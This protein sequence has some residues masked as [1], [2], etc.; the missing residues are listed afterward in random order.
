MTTGE[1]ARKRTEIEKYGMCSSHA[2]LLKN[3]MH[4]VYNA[5]KVGS[6]KLPSDKYEDKPGYPTCLLS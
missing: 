6:L 3:C 4:N 5:E 2:S 1:N